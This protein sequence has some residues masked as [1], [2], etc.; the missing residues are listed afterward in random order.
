MTDSA[1][2][3]PNGWRMNCQREPVDACAAQY[4]MSAEVSRNSRCNAT[5]GIAS[6]RAVPL[7][8]QRCACRRRIFTSRGVHR[9][10]TWPNP[11]PGT[12][13]RESSVA[14]V[15]RRFTSKSRRGSTSLAS[16]SAPSTT[17]AGSDLKQISLQKALSRGI[18]SILRYPDSRPIRSVNH[19]ERHIAFVR[20]I[21][22]S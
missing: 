8:L 18:S 2:S 20:T 7:T 15:A 5:A 4:A 19:I 21:R 16:E 11:I 1:Y 6:G 13:S 14:T 9:G 22:G 17:Q 3:T 12:K 10:A